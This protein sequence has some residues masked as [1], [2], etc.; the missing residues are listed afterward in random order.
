MEIIFKVQP[1][2][3]S[4]QNYATYYIFHLITYFVWQVKFNPAKIRFE[5]V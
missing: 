1:L 4:S 5:D 2:A 3:G